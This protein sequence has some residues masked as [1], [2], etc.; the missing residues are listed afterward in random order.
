M[1]AAARRDCAAE[2]AHLVNRK[3]E[4]EEEQEVDI[5]SVTS[6]PSRD[7]TRVTLHSEFIIPEMRYVT[8]TFL[9]IILLNS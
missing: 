5:S 4:R 3:R 2:M 6:P 8:A 1:L 7:E 9:S